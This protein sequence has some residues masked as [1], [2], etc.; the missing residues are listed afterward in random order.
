M[1]N[2]LRQSSSAKYTDKNRLAYA[3]KFILNLILFHWFIVSTITAYLFDAFLL[4][5]IGGGL[6]SAI[7]YLSYISFQGT[8]TYRYTVAIVLLTFSIIMIQQ[9]LGRIEMH[10][11]IFGALS[12]LVIYKEPRLISAAAVFIVI[13]HLL[14]NY[15]QMYNVSIFDTEIIVF[16]YGCG[17]DIVL[18][19]GA[20][21]LFEWFVLQRIV[22][23]MATVHK[24][25]YRTKDALE[26]V[27]KNL[28]SIVEARTLELKI[29]T[30]EANKANKLKSEFLANMS[31]EIR[32]PMNAIIGFTDLLEKTVQ[33]DVSKNYVKSVQDS[34]K[35]LLTI[36][37]D[38]L[39]ISKVEAGKL[40]I[41][42]QPANIK[43]ISNE[44]ENIFYHKAKEKSLDL[45]I[46]I[47]KSIPEILILDEVRTRQIL[48]NLIGNAIKFTHEGKIDVKITAS[49]TSDDNRVNLILE[50]ADTGIGM[51]E[52]EKERMFEAFAQ[53][54]NQS[55]KLYGGTGLGLS[56]TRKLVELM[57]GSIIVNSKK[58]VGSTFIVTL[59]DIKISSNNTSFKY[60][61]ENMR[62]L[63]KEATVL[64]VD[65]IDLNRNLIKEY[66]KDTPLKLIE[67]T[68][69]QEAVEIVK[70]NKIDIVLMD[71]R[72]PYKTGYEATPE[73]KQIKDIPIIAITASILNGIN[74]E[75][76][77]IFNELLFKPLKYDEL[78]SAM[79]KYIKCEITMLDTQINGNSIKNNISLHEF[80]E[81][82]ELH[83][84]AKNN[85]DI[86]LI[87]EFSEELHKYG[88]E[89]DIESFKT[90]ATQILSA[91]ESFDIGEC[92]ALLNKFN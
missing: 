61:S 53:H 1:N 6:L 31:H 41:E 29:A 9:S 8:L 76:N 21:V 54:E 51:D 10:F 75:D 4:G 42:Y 7:T 12:F 59:K 90:I 82:S 55:N 15:L 26:S 49:T 83:K 5:F 72:M 18:L 79:C 46:A 14:F 69:G 33:S 60:E 84:K 67:A 85:G 43:N 52:D 17:L 56:I 39:D 74:D 50:V 57:H 73:I 27:N 71:I 80:K 62:V 70:N 89:N 37:N 77:A 58:G 3:D 81:L 22:S 32:T 30:Q 40:Q 23:Y 38:I 87:K 91:V 11:H 63:F 86:E 28:E 16:D 78:C 25:L 92:E 35:I 48:F 36:I 24:E 34:S 68:N 64:I 2:L 66:L 47:D 19:H 13:H 65:D 20:F 44:I 45:S 88:K